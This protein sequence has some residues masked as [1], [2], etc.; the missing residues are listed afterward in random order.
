M[1][2]TK[3]ATSL[4][5]KITSERE[6][7]LHKLQELQSQADGLHLELKR[8]DG[9]INLLQTE[10][11]QMSKRMTVLTD[12]HS[13]EKQSLVGEII[14]L[15]KLNG[16]TGRQL[17][18]K[19]MELLQARQELERQLPNLKSYEQK[20]STLQAQL[21]QRSEQQKAVEMQLAEKQLE[22]LKVQSS[23]HD[24]E[25]KFYSSTAAIQDQITRELR[26]EVR[27]L[28]QQLREKDLMAEQDR[29]L[30]SKMADDSAS[31][32]KEN[33]LLH[34]QGL[35]LNKQLDRERLLKEENHSCYSSS[36]AQLFSAKN[37]VKELQYEIKMNKEALEQE[38]PKFKNFMEQICTQ[39]EGRASLD[40]N[41]ATVHSRVA[42]LQSML[43]REEQTNTQLRR[44]KALLVDLTS[45]LQKKLASKDSELSEICSRIEL[46]DQDISTLKAQRALSQSV[47]SEKWQELSNMATSMRKLTDSLDSK[48][49]GPDKY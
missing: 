34:S 20:R 31:L 49:Y 36:I 13:K 8:K 24:M 33:I 35:E 30:R 46:L 18:Q 43:A 26:D 42:E 22:I 38:T 44:D 1:E 7:V 28:H 40:L 21:D 27:L 3:K 6:R 25:E 16:H 23:L 41:T 45:D 47:Q 15:K 12:S 19:E 39:E 37:R 48:L 4:H 5:P 14:Q 10:R 9:N 17:S 32:T 11:E 29:F 2:Q